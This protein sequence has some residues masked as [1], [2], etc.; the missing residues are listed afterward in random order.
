MAA[1]AMLGLLTLVMTLVAANPVPPLSNSSSTN[2]PLVSSGE[3]KQN[4]NSSAGFNLEP[5][6]CQNPDVTLRQ[7]GFYVLKDSKGCDDGLDFFET[8]LKVH[9]KKLCKT[10]EVFVQMLCQ[11]PQRLLPPPNLVDNPCSL[12][13]KLA[14]GGLNLV[15]VRMTQS[16]LAYL[17]STLQG[18]AFK[19]NGKS[20][21]NNFCQELCMIVPRGEGGSG[22]QTKVNPQCDD[23]RRVLAALKEEERS[24]PESKPLVIPSEPKNSKSVGQEAMSSPSSST[25]QKEKEL[26]SSVKK[27]LPTANSTVNS[28]VSATS[29]GMTPSNPSGSNSQTSSTIVKSTSAVKSTSGKPNIQEI[30]VKEN[31]PED[32]DAMT[33]AEVE[34]DVHE[35]PSRVAVDNMPANPDSEETPSYFLSY[36]F[37]LTIICIAGYLILHNKNKLMGLI[38]EGRRP[39]NGRGGGRRRSSSSSNSA[40]Y[41]KLDNNLEE[42]MGPNS[43]TSFS[44]VVY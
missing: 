12:L 22:D 14:L 27:A 36:F 4:K 39:R 13:A 35:K 7:D 11:L 30:S 20:A 21:G 19:S 28:T 3:L 38:L 15:K 43:N 26:G 24:P 1:L 29:P 5:T 2:K 16:D 6:S 44:Q 34:D 23:L 8:T 32:D 10:N 9:Y 31:P 18:L 42:A 33:D 40:R 25:T 41:R 37:A 17:N